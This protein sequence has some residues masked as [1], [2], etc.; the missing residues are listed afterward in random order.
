MIASRGSLA[1]APLA[2]TTLAGGTFV[3]DAAAAID[4]T[5]GGSATLSRAAVRVS[6]TIAATAGLLATAV[7][8]RPVTGAA[9]IALDTAAAATRRKVAIAAV[10]VAVAVEASAV[11]RRSVSTNADVDVDAA[12]AARMTRPASAD[13]QAS[14]IVSA[15]MRGGR[16][17]VEAH[18]VVEAG[19][20]ALLR[21]RVPLP[22]AVA[23]MEAAVSV[24]ARRRERCAARIEVTVGG[25]GDLHWLRM[26][27]PDETGRRTTVPTTER[28]QDLGT[29]APAVYQSDPTSA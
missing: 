16:L 9:G 17:P 25:T 2:A 1:G 22:P 24:L 23:G 3:L 12:G 26:C 7:R 6:A 10:A 19:G 14:V 29:P 11:R 21:H 20:S 4:I 13:L 18:V 28:L 5:L 8:R 15:A 27:P